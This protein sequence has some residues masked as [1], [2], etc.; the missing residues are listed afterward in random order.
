MR[1]GASGRQ[2]LPP[3]GFTMTPDWTR[4]PDGRSNSSEEYLKAVA[5]VERMIRNSA[6]S[7]ING[8]VHDV[9]RLIVSQLAFVHGLGPKEQP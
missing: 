3:S 7:L 2:A 4:G 5:A 9:A 8:Q 1:F 6:F